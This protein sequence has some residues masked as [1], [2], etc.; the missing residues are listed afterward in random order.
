MMLPPEELLRPM[1]PLRHAH[2]GCISFLCFLL[3][4]LSTCSADSAQWDSRHNRRRYSPAMDAAFNTDSQKYYFFHGCGY[5]GRPYDRP[6][7]G[8]SSIAQNWSSALE[9]LDAAC[10]CGTSSTYYVTYPTAPHVS[11]M[12]TLVHVNRLLS[13]S[14]RH[15]VLHWRCLLQQ[16]IWCSDQRA[17][18]NQH[19]GRQPTVRPRQ[20]R[21]QRAHTEV[22]L[23]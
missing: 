12:R 3:R 18:A 5:S 21:L 7:E 23:W 1:Q 14:C 2:H 6:T 13:A 10:Y 8:Q 11:V 19:L 4:F 16:G 9:H 20:R 17:E 22:L 15:V